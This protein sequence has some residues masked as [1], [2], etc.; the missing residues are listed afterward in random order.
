M[1]E[2]L[3]KILHDISWEIGWR[4]T[5]LGFFLMNPTRYLEMRDDYSYVINAMFMLVVSH[6]I[7]A[8]FMK[9]PKRPK[10]ATN[11]LDE[12]AGKP[13]MLRINYMY[14][15]NTKKLYCKFLREFVGKEAS[16]Y[17]HD[18][19]MPAHRGNNPIEID[20][21]QWFVISIS[22]MCDGVSEVVQ[23]QPVYTLTEN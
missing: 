23:V 15:P 22:K 12:E 16:S 13:Y 10:S 21:R 1:N 19:I 18:V 7:V 8:A 2:F 20:G 3:Q 9:W 14:P 11:V 5:E 17:K 6:C 4:M